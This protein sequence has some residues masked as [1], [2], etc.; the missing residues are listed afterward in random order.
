M[1]FNCADYLLLLLLLLMMMMMM[2]NN[3][4]HCCSTRQLQTTHSTVDGGATP[5]M[6][7]TRR[8]TGP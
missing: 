8:Q 7:F 2:H 3:D 4:I 1:Y 6:S 5:R